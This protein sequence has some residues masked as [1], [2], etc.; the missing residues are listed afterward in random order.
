[1]SNV[2]THLDTDLQASIFAILRSDSALGQIIGDRIYDNVPDEETFPYVVI[3][4]DD[5][6]DWTTHTFKGF[7]GTSTINVWS[8]RENERGKDEVKR[9]MSLIWLALDNKDLGLPNRIQVNFSG[10]RSFVLTESDNRT[11]QGVIIFT[12]IFGG[13][14]T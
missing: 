12:F 13:N 4:D 7:K 6:N 1:M 8:R 14:E 10:E 2:A 9:I 5:V 3:G 11:Q